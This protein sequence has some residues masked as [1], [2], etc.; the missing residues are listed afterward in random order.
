[1]RTRFSESNEMSG[2]S[3]RRTEVADHN[4]KSEPPRNL[5]IDGPPELL[6]GA[7]AGEDLVG[8]AG[9]SVSLL[10][11]A[12]PVLYKLLST[13]MKRQNETLMMVAAA[14]GA[15]PSV[16]A[17]E[18]SALMNVTAEGYPG[19]RFFAG[20]AI[21]DEIE[22]LAIARAKA[23]FGA[24]YANVQPHSGN[25]ANLCVIMA[26]LSPRDTLL[27]LDLNSGGHLS[28]GS[29]ASAVGRH[30]NCIA[31]GLDQEGLIDL[32]QVYDLAQ[33]YRPK[34]IVCGASTYARTIDFKRFREIADSVGAFLLA[35]ISHISGLVAA[36]EHPSSIDHAHFTTT[37]TYKQLF[38]PRGGLILMGRDADGPSPSGKG[39]LA[40]FV[41]RAVFPS[42]QSTPNLAAIAAKARALDMVVTDAFRQLARLIVL[43]A[44]AL[45]KELLFRGYRVLT[46]GTD[47]HMVIL[48]IR[49]SGLT[50]VAAERALEDCGIVVNRN[51][52]PGD[53]RPARIASGLRLG[54]NTLA[55]RGMAEREMVHCGELLNTVLRSTTAV[56]DEDY[57]LEPSAQKKVSMAVREL[58]RRFPLPGY[59]LRRTAPIE[60]EVCPKDGVSLNRG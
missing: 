56:A 52:I 49:D 1:M 16:L 60:D 43:D 29:A 50:G 2:A 48:D 51:R 41:Q 24:R 3:A 37:S 42:G 25:S 57:K 46:G 45:A 13:E 18:G 31:Y 47:N 4:V 14:S 26:V 7:G 34:L 12:D 32:G 38:G 21:A 5:Q 8:F 44:K 53:S 6:G 19:A 11:E 58:C 30:F 10:A 59:S 28:H 39:T 17:C 35:D 22:R 33:R 27:G 23:A 36:G 9:R 55:L 40:E 20:C 54:T 15:H